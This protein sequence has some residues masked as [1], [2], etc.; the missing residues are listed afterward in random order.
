VATA[1]DYTRPPIII[2]NNATDTVYLNLYGGNN[3]QAQFKCIVGTIYNPGLSFQNNER[4]GFSNPGTTPTF[5]SPIVNLS[6]CGYPSVQFTYNQ[7]SLINQD[8]GACLNITGS[9]STNRTVTFPDATGIPAIFVAAPGSLSDP[10]VPGMIAEG[11]NNFYYYDTVT[12]AWIKIGG[13]G[14]TFDLTNGES[15][16]TLLP[17]MPVYRSGLDL[18]KRGNANSLTTADLV[19]LCITTGAPS[20]V[21]TVQAG[22]ELTL[23]TSQWDAVTGGSGGLLEVVYFLDITTGKITSTPTTTTGIGNYLVKIGKG[24]N[25]TNMLIDISDPY[26]L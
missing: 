19:G 6:V 13:S 14:A 25:T 16:T 22:G 5:A 21:V 4:T 8:T 11:N 26:L 18:A 23:T 24:I 9:Q 10:G 7:L 1:F 2:P 12:S 3:Y 17:G 20:V 15:S